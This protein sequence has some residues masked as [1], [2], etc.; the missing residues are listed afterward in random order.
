[1]ISLYCTN[2]HRTE[3][4]SVCNDCSEV[5]NYSF[6]R[7]DNCVFGIEKPPCKKCPVHCYNKDMR[8]KIKTIMRFSGPRMIW[9]HPWFAIMHIIDKFNS[10]KISNGKQKP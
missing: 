6:K 2:R 4:G 8:E 10:Q 3:T 7:I 1:M 9:A 5:L